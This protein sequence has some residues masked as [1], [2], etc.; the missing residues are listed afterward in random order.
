AIA[1]AH[2]QLK[3]GKTE[4]EMLEIVNDEMQKRGGS[5]GGLVQ[6]G[7]DAALPHGEPGQRRLERNTTVL[8]DVGCR[9]NGYTSD[10]TRTI[11][12]GGEVPSKFKEV[13]N[14]VWNAQQAGF[15]TARAGVECQ[16]VD[17][18]ARAVI[19]RAGYGKYFTH[20]LGHGLG[21]DGH[22]PPYLVEGND[23]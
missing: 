11:F 7:S 20:R 1:A 16:A 18:A 4:L 14:T 19:E 2:L 6:F 5:P 23:F 15:E 13:F 17:R 9:V 8:M 22:E 12:W 10:I 3:E 21:L